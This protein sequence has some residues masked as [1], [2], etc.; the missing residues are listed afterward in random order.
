MGDDRLNSLDN[1]F[2]DR[3]TVVRRPKLTYDD[4]G[5]NASALPPTIEVATE[6]V[7]AEQARNDALARIEGKLDAVIEALIGLQRR[8]ESIDAVIARILMRHLLR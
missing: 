2:G 1:D 6:L 3:F 4:Y 7:P 5:T 8:I